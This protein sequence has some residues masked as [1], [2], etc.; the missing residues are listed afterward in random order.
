MAFAHGGS[1]PLMLFGGLVGA[2]LFRCTVG[3]P[4]FS[5]RTSVGGFLQTHERMNSEARQLKDFPPPLG[6]SAI[7]VIDMQND[8]VDPR[9]SLS[10]G[11]KE[12]VIEPINELLEM[13]WHLR[14]FTADYHPANHV[15][16]KT[17][18]PSDTQII[19]N[20]PFPIV[21]IEYSE[22]TQSNGSKICG[23][24]YVERY[25]AAADELNGSISVAQE[26]YPPH[27]VQGTWGQ[28]IHPELNFDYNEP[29]DHI[30]LKGTSAH[31]D[32][33]SAVFNN[34]ACDGPIRYDAA[35][36]VLS[37][38]CIPKT[39]PYPQETNLP[40]LLRIAGIEHVFF[41]GVCFDYCVKY[42]AIHTAFLGWDTYIVS[43]ASKT[44]GSDAHVNDTYAQLQDHGVKIID[45]ASLSA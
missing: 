10:S 43:D 11:G 14:A 17:N 15:S 1:V 2:T 29:K 41:V 19:E 16:F 9:G 6:K 7:I 31:I 35:G 4:N 38:A 8:F 20:G 39:T 23:A 45:S 22:L 21:Q 32:S 37:S 25:G 28:K 26:T 13:D 33:Y 40:D 12:S 42:S 5:A 34:I 3:A 30:I 27:C 18:H 36:E 24:E 44:C